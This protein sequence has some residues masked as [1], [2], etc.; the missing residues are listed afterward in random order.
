MSHD[1]PHPDRMDGSPSE[2]PPIGPRAW[3]E[4]DPSKTPGMW[5]KKE[6]VDRLLKVF[7]VLCGIVVILDFV[8]H[9]HI[10]HP[11][12][13][14]FGFHAWWGFASFWILVAVAKRMRKVLM[15]PEDYYDVD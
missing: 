14:L 3:L 9:R 2:P 5:D 13:S 10:Y 8:A 15:R 7:Y 4:E 11:W 1:A 6:N 12:E